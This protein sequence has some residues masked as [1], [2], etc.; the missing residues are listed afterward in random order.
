ML[1]ILSSVTRPTGLHVDDARRR[2]WIVLSDGTLGSVDLDGGSLTVAQVVPIRA[3][4]ITANASTLVMAARNGGLWTVDADHPGSAAGRVDSIKGSPLQVAAGRGVKPVLLTVAR[5]TKRTTLT[6]TDL[7][8]G[9]HQD[10]PIRGASGVLV[11]GRDVYLALNDAATGTGTIALLRS[12][13]LRT[14]TPDL[15][16]IGRIGLAKG[17]LLA[18]H[19]SIGAL[20]A[21]LPST[22]T[23]TTGSLA[24]LPG[25]LLEAQGLDDGRIAVLTT[26]VLAIADS[27]TDFEQRP[28]IVPPADPLFVGSWTRLRFSLVGTGLDASTVHLEVPDGP[29]A[30]LVSYAR[31]DGAGDPEPL[32]VAGGAVGRY[33]IALVE[34]ATG[35]VLADAAFE[36]TD[37]WHDAD[38]GPSRM[39]AGAT[40]MEGSSGWGGGPNT[41]QNLGDLTHTGT[42]NT[43]VLMVDTST[44]RWPTSPAAT[45]TA[46]QTAVL[47]HVVNGIAFNAQTRSVRQY[48]EENSGYV[49]PSGG[50]PGRGLTIAARNA[51]VYGPVNLPNP[52]TT[53]FQQKKDATGNVIDARWSSAGTTAQTIISQAL[54]SGALTRADLTAIDALIIV[55]RSPDASSAAGNRFVWP[56][57]SVGKRRL[58]LGTNVMT[59]QGDLAYAYAPL[60]FAA[61]DG[62][63]MHTT[64]SHELGHNLGLLDVYD[65]EEYSDDVTARITSDWEMMAG[66]RDRL[67]HFSLSNKMR[68]G[69]VP[70]NQLRLYNFQGSGGVNDPITLHPTERADPPAGRFR[71]I[72]IRLGDGLNYYV[73]YRAEQGSQVSDDLPT[74]RRVIVTDVTSEDFAAPLARPRI[75]FVPNDIDGDGPIIGSGSDFEDKDPGTQMDLAV[76]VI[77][78]SVDQAAVR[79]TYGSQGKPEPGI[80]PWNGGPTWQSPDIEVRNDRATAEPAKWFNV[81]WLGHD[82]T[83]VAKVRNAGDLTATGVVVDFFA[84]EFTT[85]DGPWVSLGNATRDVGPGATVEFSRPWNPSAADGR[86]YCVIVR[87]RLYQAPGNPAIVDQNIYNNEA[88]SNY[89]SFISASASPSTRVGTS[90]L[91]AN[92]FARS[93]LVF[94]EVKQTHP[95]H[96][97]FVEHDWLRVDGRAARPVGV[98]DEALW[99]TAEWDFVG[100][101]GQRGPGYLWE[102]PNR[103]SIDGWAIRPYQTDCGASVLTG[104]AGLQVHAGRATE[105]K[106][107]KHRITYTTGDVR[108]ADNGDPVTSG[109]VL[110]EVSDGERSFTV[111]TDVRAD[112]RFGRDYDNPFGDH[113]KWLQAHYLGSFSA[114]AAESGEVEPER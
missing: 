17:A 89:T 44:A 62:R 80:R 10:L 79:V 93:T 106:L 43:I 8:K 35:A 47:G 112:G 64:L 42:W 9:T 94:A 69:W 59:E 45:V 104:G 81:P 86:H 3:V 58:L 29:Q 105:I 111:P 63:Q 73:E 102:V 101:G 61:H 114:A 33:R 68:M 16:P 107:D 96:R 6:T 95:Q 22:G 57:A 19:P 82:N 85:G 49:A 15:P 60:D 100:E 113:T 2:I 13:R 75:M 20:S 39:V 110:I 65:I 108:F 72:E 18:C 66:S 98:F 24:D 23:V 5:T 31:V 11:S 55:P 1:T 56:H 28:F 88:R 77:S 91:L 87:I 50:N 90:V 40:A 76:S 53:Y 84:T 21:V 109:V 51:R 71:G 46:D 48:Y 36:V 26:E 30:G 103:V 37:H 52:W 99:G 7:K 78:T 74:D 25:T 70:A 34:D 54:S 97:V 14:V 38:T 92:P 41:P 4:D 32:L 27:V 67:P 12:G 83:I